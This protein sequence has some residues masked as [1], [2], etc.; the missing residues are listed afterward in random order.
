MRYAVVGGDMRFAHLARMLEESGREARGF[1]HQ[2]AGNAEELKEYDV[3]ISNWPMRFPLAGGEVSAENV[4]ENI[5]AGGTLLCCGPK[6]PEVAPEGMRC[7]NLWKDE[8]LLRENAYL[9]AEAAV[10]IA[11]HRCSGVRDGSCTVIGYGRIGSALVEI[12]TNM[13]ARVTLLSRTMEKRRLA[14]AAGAAAGDMA[15]AAEMQRALREAELIFTTPPAEVLDGDMLA[16]IR[17]EALLIDLASPPYGFDLDVARGMGLQAYR[18]SGLP[19]RYCP[20]SAARAIYGAVLR[21][22]EGERHG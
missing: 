19:G 1:F 7:V 22:E 11:M 2:R 12:L 9:T 5:A 15:N 21:W 10:A 17:P 6:F 18:E 16:L 14:C 8:R 13:G 20:L 3:V 4:M